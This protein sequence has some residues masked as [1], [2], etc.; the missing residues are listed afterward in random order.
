[1][2]FIDND[3]VRRVLSISDVIESQEEVF[4][5]LL[6]RDSVHRG[7]IDVYVPTG[8]E[9]DYYRWGT[10]EGASK[11]LGVHAIRMKSD[12]V[13]WP[14]DEDGNYTTEEKYCVEPGTYC[15]LIMLFSTR[16]GEPLAL[17][18][19]GH[20]QH[21][22][23]A[24][25]AG[26]GAKYLSRASSEVVGMFGSGGM[27]RDYLRAFL[28]VRP[29]IRKVKVYSP[30]RANR[31][32]YAREMGA[33]LEIE[34]EP[35]DRPEDVVPGADIVSTCTDTMQPVVFGDWLEPGQH[36]T[37]LGGYEWHPSVFERA[38]IVLRNGIGNFIARDDEQRVEIG[39]GHSPGAFIAG[40]DAEVERLPPARPSRHNSGGDRIPTFVD[41]VAGNTPGRTE[42]S[43][44]TA[45]I[46]GGYQGLQFAAAGAVAYRRAREEGLG[47]ELPTEWFL[48]D[49]RD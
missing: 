3:T 21:M 34:I 38:D 10:M 39:R 12:I 43:Q 4:K 33:E 8:R 46:V 5:G 9:D 13:S 1:M 30:T 2:L 29:S 26:I 27:A 24:A 40:S 49:I 14:R 25:G 22:R 17:I 19:D 7:R 45:Y 37:N 28:A 20:L 31:E 41:L 16:N 18:N 23:V 48:Q 47:R 44:I 15:G 6:T 42:D 35:V 11:T 32:R 36:V